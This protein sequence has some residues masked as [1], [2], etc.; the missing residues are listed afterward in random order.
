MSSQLFA[1]QLAQPLESHSDERLSGYYD[2]QSQLLIWESGTRAQ[3]NYVCSGADWSL[4]YVSCSAYGNYCNV[5]EKVPDN[6]L[7]YDCD[8]L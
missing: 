6:T 3:S 4:G 1:F 2:H 7:G 8:W 5:G